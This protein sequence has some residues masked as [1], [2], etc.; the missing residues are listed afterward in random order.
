MPNWERGHEPVEHFR[1]EAERLAA[2]RGAESPTDPRMSWD[3]EVDDAGLVWVVLDPRFPGFAEAVS[4]SIGSLSPA[5]SEAKLSTYWI[6]RTL[7][8]LVANEDSSEAV[9]LSSGNMSALERQGSIVRAVALYETF[10]PEELSADEV[11]GGLL[12]W[13][14][15]VLDRISIHGDSVPINEAGG[16][17][18]MRRPPH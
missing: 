3:F 16:V 5:G 9:Q 1:S 8:W 2:E 17:V 7:T 4:D 12:A 11:I 10:E 6:D 13:R 15:T 18:G 14:R